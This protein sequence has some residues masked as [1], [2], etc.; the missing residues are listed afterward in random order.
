MIS[1]TLT[2]KLYCLA[3][4]DEVREFRC[5]LPAFLLVLREV[6]LLSQFHVIHLSRENDTIL[7]EGGVPLL[8]IPKALSLYFSQVANF[9]L[10]SISSPFWG[11]GECLIHPSCLSGQNPL[12]YTQ[13]SLYTFVELIEDWWFM[14][15]GSN[16]WHCSC[17]NRFFFSVSIGCEAPEG[18]AWVPH[19]SFWSVLFLLTHHNLLSFYLLGVN[20]FKTSYNFLNNQVVLLVWM[21]CFCRLGQN[22]ILKQRLPREPSSILW[23]HSE[24]TELFTYLQTWLTG[25]SLPLNHPSPVPLQCLPLIYLQ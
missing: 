24:I 10:L 18:E 25:L 21:P 4:D 17:L 2:R 19:V 3:V 7:P 14:S 12:S 16:F 6:K 23:L 13:S 20:D 11:K 5:D 22:F 9:P 15:F 1:T 8:W